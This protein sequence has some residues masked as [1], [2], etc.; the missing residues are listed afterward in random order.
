MSLSLHS[1]HSLT[2][3]IYLQFHFLISIYL[4][5]TACTG[6]D[7]DRV[8]WYLKQIKNVC[9]ITSDM[10]TMTAID[11]DQTAWIWTMN[12]KNWYKINAARQK[13]IKIFCTVHLYLQ[14]KILPKYFHQITI[15]V[16]LWFMDCGQH[17]EI[18]LSKQAN[19]IK[20]SNHF[21]TSPCK[22]LFL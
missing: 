11:V 15:W 22:R 3:D 21:V 5:S 18:S 9:K 16:I 10:L 12:K 4:Y 6:T 19:F 17:S 1:S 8:D 2:L 7:F 20:I 14:T 13:W